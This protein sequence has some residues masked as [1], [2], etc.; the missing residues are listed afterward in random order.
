MGAFSKLR[1]QIIFHL[2]VIE[3]TG[4]GFASLWLALLLF[5]GITDGVG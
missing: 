3:I 2:P 4:S 1:Y 5:S